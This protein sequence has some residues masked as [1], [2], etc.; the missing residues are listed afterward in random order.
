M[1]SGQVPPQTARASS[2]TFPQV[3]TEAATYCA[4]TTVGT[5]LQVSLR[6]IQSQKRRRRSC[7]KQWTSLSPRGYRSSR[8]SQR[9]RKHAGCR[10]RSRSPQP[11]ALHGARHGRHALRVLPAFLACSAQ[12]VTNVLHEAFP[13]EASPALPPSLLQG[14]I[15]LLYKGKEADRESPASYCA[16]QQ[17]GASQC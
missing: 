9:R 12:E 6:H 14:R 15:T 4:T 3:G 5:W 13:T 8:G 11:A 16:C 17:T 10:A 1:L 7:Y 2:W